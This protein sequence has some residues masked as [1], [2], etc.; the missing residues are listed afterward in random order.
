[1]SRLGIEVFHGTDFAVPYLARRPGVLTLHDLSPWMNP[2]WHAAADRVR[3]RTPLLLGLHIATMII[4][5]SEAV[6]TEAIARFGIHPSRIV[7]VPNAAS[8]MFRP[9][10]V[11]RPAVP[12]FLFVGT[13]E[14]RKNVPA[15]VDAWRELRR[16]HRADLVLAGRRR[17]DF[18]DLPAEEGLKVLGEVPDEELPRLYSGA[19]AV[20]YPSWYEGFGLPV[21]EAM[22]SG[23]CV[24]TSTDPAVRELSGGAGFATPAQ[25]VRRLAEVMAAV[26]SQPDRAA[27]ARRRALVRARSFSWRRSARIT[28]EVYEE[29]RRRFG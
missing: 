15:L 23:A 18:R 29:A 19:S 3:R 16:I 11:D 20:V 22:Q 26:L 4:S 28:R 21:L 7:T 2:E 1:M 10:P 5:V 25:D 27:E 13:L 8:E 24:I 6:R 14:P 12:Y 17:D 9:V